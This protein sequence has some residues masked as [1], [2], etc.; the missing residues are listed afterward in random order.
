[1]ER[2][3]G[4]FAP[5]AYLDGRHVRS[6]YVEVD[7]RGIIV[8][9]GAEIPA[10]APPHVVDLGRAL[11]VPGFVDAHS[12]AF[13]RLIRGR[14]QRR[15]AHDPSSFW[16]WRTAMYDVAARL[17]PDAFEAAAT[18]VFR[19]MAAAGITCV[20]E[21]HYLHHGPDGTPY[22]DPNEMSLRAV[23]A[24]R[25]VGIRIVMLEVYYA[26]AGAGRPPEGA[27]VRF[28]DG[29]VDAYLARI[30]AL[31]DAGAAVGIAPHS[32]RAVGRADLARLV[33]H[34]RD[35]SLPLHIHLSEQPAENEACRA[36]HGTTPAGLLDELGA[37]DGCNTTCVHATFLD[38]DD[39][40]RLGRARV[41]LCPTT[42]ADLGDGLP[43]A[44]PLLAAG[45][46]FC[47]GSDSNAIVD[48]VQEARLAEMGER[49][50]TNR[51]LCLAA[52]GRT[53]AETLLDAATREGAAALGLAGTT[54]RLAAGE[55][56]DACVVDLDDP[57]F[58]EVPDDALLDAWLLSG[59][60]APVR[61]TYVG[62]ERIH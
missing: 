11:L 24:A 14:T 47:F 9:T 46:R 12:H 57:M 52:K 50:R 39:V 29:S 60:A 22:A 51:R 16:S 36:E 10:D 6:A 33:S 31:A 38:A 20:G 34:A 26:R 54:G 15:G 18:L 59:T 35:R 42:E 49:L 23:A 4:F 30:E 8:R 19:E 55:A 5:H 61:A 48:L 13:Q 28:C 40:A 58:A 27:Q 45:T 1:M 32:V 3:T 56:F 17:D 37:F 43:P 41:C 2:R 53:V 62:G 21:F 44:G 7:E 25:A